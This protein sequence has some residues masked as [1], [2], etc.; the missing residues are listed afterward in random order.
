MQRAILPYAT[1]KATKFHGP[2]CRLSASTGFKSL[3]V[4]WSRELARSLAD[5]GKRVC[6]AGP[7]HE[8]RGG[9]ARLVVHSEL[10]GKMAEPGSFR[11]VRHGADLSMEPQWTEQETTEF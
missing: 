9:Q 7:Y 8:L 6:G 10:G 2:H 3:F 11:L 4:S 1:Q 5:C